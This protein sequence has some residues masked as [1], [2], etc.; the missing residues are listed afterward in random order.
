MAWD[1]VGIATIWYFVVETKKISLEEL[2]DIFEASNPRKK[3]SA[4]FKQAKR[5]AA[6]EK[7][8][9]AYIDDTA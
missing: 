1:L 7:R 6:A 8:G 9:E 2:D 4:L 3:A 5:R